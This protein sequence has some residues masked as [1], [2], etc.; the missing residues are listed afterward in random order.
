MK[1]KNVQLPIAVDNNF[2]ARQS[3]ARAGIGAL[4]CWGVVRRNRLHLIPL[5][6]PT[7]ERTS[8]Q[9]HMSEQAPMSPAVTPPVLP[10]EN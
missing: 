1:K 5:Q 6:A 7:Q 8:P 3:D 10:A 4:P 2:S 9:Q